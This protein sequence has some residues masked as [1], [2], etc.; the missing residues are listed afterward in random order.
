MQRQLKTRNSLGNLQN[1]LR[2]KFRI[3]FLSKV[4]AVSH[5]IDHYKIS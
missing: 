2:V 5:K 3:A 4:T 1:K